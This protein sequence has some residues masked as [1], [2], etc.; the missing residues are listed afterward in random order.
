MTVL[1]KFITR[2]TKRL[3]K[4]WVKSIFKHHVYVPR[5]G[6]AKGFKVTG[7]LGFLRKPSYTREGGRFQRV[8][9]SRFLNHRLHF[10]VNSRPTHRL[11]RGFQPEIL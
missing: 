5:Q 2:R 8:I 7:D 6:L 1:V 4:R 3:L 9:L 10:S 11:R